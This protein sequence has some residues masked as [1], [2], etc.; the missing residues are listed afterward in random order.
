M[1]NMIDATEG[2]DRFRPQQSVCV[3]NN[4]DEN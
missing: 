1:Q 3:G 2:F 4:A